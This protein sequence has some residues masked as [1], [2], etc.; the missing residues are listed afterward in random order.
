MMLRRL[1]ASLR[2]APKRARFNSTSSA[3][4][5]TSHAQ[6][7]RILVAA[8]LLGA[9]AAGYMLGSAKSPVISP[10]SISSTAHY[11]SKAHFEKAIS[12]LQA[13]LGED[14]VSID[15]EDLHAHGYSENDHHPG[16]FL[17]YLASFATLS[18]RICRH[19]T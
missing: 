19:F 7:T 9:G 8:A 18:Y 12:E 3:S 10:P 13:A 1:L 5:N 11:G 16:A 14:K 17:C 15:S 2:S 4:V 6:S